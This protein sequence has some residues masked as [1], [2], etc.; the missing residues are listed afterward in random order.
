MPSKFP[1]ASSGSATKSA[2]SA[3]S[4][5]SAAASA[6]TKAPGNEFVSE[7]LSSAKRTSSAARPS[8]AADLKGMADIA[9]RI[10]GLE[11]LIYHLCYENDV[12]P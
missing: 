2:A 3:A 8:S 1:S 6:A 9:D 11:K 5:G 10:P 12:M 7:M 4:R